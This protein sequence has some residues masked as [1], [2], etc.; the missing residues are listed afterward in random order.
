LFW[1]QERG[2]ANA[3]ATSGAGDCHA[4]VKPGHDSDGLGCRFAF[5]RAFATASAPTALDYRKAS[6][7][8]DYRNRNAR[9]PQEP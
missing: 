6:G 3:R 5:T 1:D 2:W 7:H 9:D 8:P 4:P